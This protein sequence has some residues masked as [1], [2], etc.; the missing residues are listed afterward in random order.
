MDLV[1]WLPIFV[2]YLPVL[3]SRA[4]IGPKDVATQTI[5]QQLVQRWDSGSKIPS[6]ADILL[7]MSRICSNQRVR[8]GSTK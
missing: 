3:L 6:V 7:A 5:E 1:L 4:T 2:R 8:F